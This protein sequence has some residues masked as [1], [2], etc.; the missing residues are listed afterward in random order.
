MAASSDSRSRPREASTEPLNRDQPRYFNLVWDYELDELHEV[1]EAVFTRRAEVLSRWHELYV[2]HFGDSRSLS[3]AEFSEIFGTELNTTLQDLL[4]KDMDRFAAHV[5]QVGE[6]LAQ[7]NV[8]FSEVIVSMHLFEDSAVAVFPS[9]APQDPKIYTSF[10]KLSHCRT[11]VL[12]DTY[13][14]SRS[15]LLG[16]RIKDLQREAAKLPADGRT[17]FHGLV[18]A[19]LEMRKL[20]QRIE[21]VGQTRGTVL[22]VGESGTGKELVARAIHECGANP[23]APFVALNCAAIPKDLIESELFGYKRGAFSGATAE[24]LGLFRAAEGGTLFLDE[25]TEMSGETQSKLLRTLQEHTVRPVGAT[26]EVAVNARVIASTNRDPEE[27]MRAGQLRPDLYYR[28]QASVLQVPPLRERLDDVPSLVEHFITL[29]NERLRPRTPIIAVSSQALEAMQ[30][31]QWPGNVRELSNVIESAF[32]FGDSPV[33]ELAQLPPAIGGAGAPSK[34]AATGPITTFAAAER[35]LIAR[36]L[37]STGG[38]KVA[39]A[40]LLRISRKKLYG[41]IAK[42]QLG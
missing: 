20:Y 13:F 38:N 25:I 8:P 21:A 17:V 42:Y 36:A 11:I 3:E 7:R 37:E 19:N 31:Y 14:R 15:A 18:G 24:Y 28:L 2:L 10:D 16:A 4:S 12:A 39:A 33:I 23:N 26:R 40:K 6:M 5:R 29:F 1:L 27:A 41:K 9:F 22:I 35:D 32:T 30:H 34:S